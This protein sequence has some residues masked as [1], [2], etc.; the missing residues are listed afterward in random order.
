VPVPDTSSTLGK[1]LVGP[2]KKRLDVSANRF[3]MEQPDQTSWWNILVSVVAVLV[4]FG[5]LPFL[6][7]GTEIQ[8]RLGQML[9]IVGLGVVLKWGYW[10]NRR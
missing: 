8:T 6:W 7:N 3:Q 4:L 2:M 1:V 10:R 5:T 9:S